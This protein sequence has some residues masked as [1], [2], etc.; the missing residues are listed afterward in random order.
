[1]VNHYNALSGPLYA[2]RVR[3][4]KRS[5]S[6]PTASSSDLWENRLIPAMWCHREGGGRGNNH[7]SR[8]SGWILTGGMVGE[9]KW[10]EREEYQHLIYPIMLL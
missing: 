1:M 3:G 10:E 6:A 7:A 8:V 5:T 2:K 4:R 9:E